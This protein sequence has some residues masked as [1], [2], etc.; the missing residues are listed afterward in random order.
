M[1]SNPPEETDPDL[2]NAVRLHGTS[3]P[4]TERVEKVV[5][6]LISAYEQEKSLDER[7]GQNQEKETDE[8]DGPEM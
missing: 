1:S 8:L 4:A 2:T 6:Q 5:F 3:T 7:L